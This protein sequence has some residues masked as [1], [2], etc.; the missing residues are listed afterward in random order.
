MN[1]T[2]LFC[3]AVATSLV[4]GL[5]L[6]RV[7]FKDISDFATGLDTLFRNMAQQNCKTVKVWAW[8]L[9]SIGSGLVLYHQLPRW[10]PGAF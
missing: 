9:I 1:A 3:V 6:F 10:F 5:V 2:R 4:V 8:A 7:L